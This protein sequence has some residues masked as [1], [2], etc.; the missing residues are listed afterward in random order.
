MLERAGGPTS[1]PCRTCPWR[2]TSTVG[3][4]D[5]PGFDIEKMRGLRKTVGDG[6]DFRTVMACHYSPEGEEKPC[7]GYVHVEGYSNIFV[8]LLDSWGR[9]DLAAIDEAC[10]GIEMWPSFGEMLAAYEAAHAAEEERRAAE[11]LEEPQLYYYVMEDGRRIPGVSKEMKPGEAR[12]INE[13]QKKLLLYG[14]WKTETEIGAAPVKT[15][16][17]KLSR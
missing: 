12:R 5:I 7:I 2:K 3:G 1:A 9:I 17:Y 13:R 11:A 6:D 4:F 10:R 8:R 15:R 14:R 16:V